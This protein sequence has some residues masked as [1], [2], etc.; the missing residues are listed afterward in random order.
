MTFRSKI[1]NAKAKIKSNCSENVESPLTPHLLQIF[2]AQDFLRDKFI[3]Q[4]ICVKFPT[5]I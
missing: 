3:C 1:V 2:I 4:D 5:Y